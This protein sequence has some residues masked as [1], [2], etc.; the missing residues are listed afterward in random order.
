MKKFFNKNNITNITDSQKNADIIVSES[1]SNNNYNYYK[2]CSTDKLKDSSIYDVKIFIKENSHKFSF[3]I[4][5][6]AN[7]NFSIKLEKLNRFPRQKYTSIPH[8]KKNSNKFK[9]NK[10]NRK[11]STSQEDTLVYCF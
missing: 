8:R 10:L 5:G 11:K 4:Y 9:A 3:K 7:A 1:K 2:S 6:K